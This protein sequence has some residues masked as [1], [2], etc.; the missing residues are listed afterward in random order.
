[1]ENLNDKNNEVPTD[2][3]TA[4]EE[5]TPAVS[6]ES[7]CTSADPQPAP[8][9]E[10]TIE[11][12]SE[13]VN[14][15]SCCEP[16]VRNDDDGE[17]EKKGR[18]VLIFAIIMSVC[19]AVTLMALISSFLFGGYHWMDPTDP[20]TTDVPSDSNTPDEGQESSKPSQPSEPKPGEGETPDPDEIPD[21]GGSS[22]PTPKPDVDV[23]Y[24]NGELKLGD[25]SGKELTRQEIS[26]LGNP[27]VVAITVTKTAGTGIG[28]GVIMTEDG[29]IATN[30]HVVEDAK[31]ITVQTYDGK[32]FNAVTVGSSVLDDLAVIKIDA[33]DL[34]FATFGDSSS[35]Q[36]GD[37][38]TVI[39]HPAGLKFGWT[40]TYGYV[41]AINRDVEIHNYDGTLLHKMTL[42]QIDADVNKG[43]SGGPMFNDRGEVIGIINMRLTGSYEGMGFAIPSKVAV[44]LLES[45]MK[46]GTTDGVEPESSSERPHIGITGISLEK[47]HYYWVG[48]TFVYKL[49][50]A[51]AATIEGSFKAEATGV[52][53]TSVSTASDAYGKLI[54][55]DIITA[56]NGEVMSTMDEMRE[57]LYGLRIGDTVTIT[58]VRDGEEQTLSVLLTPPTK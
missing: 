1:M 58:Y 3:R 30:A 43:N 21:E 42:L 36:V 38:T 29:Y 32:T 37:S 7:D 49:S 5:A 31:T 8:D 44:P 48:D 25:G 50:E 56:I 51:Q 9:E 33:D 20:D 22:E 4:R 19:F 53:V 57:Y 28:S 14:Q 10:G 11:A 15:G 46:T 24:G 27:V 26:A 12:E 47:D 17:E 2:D 34:P 35:V 41:S 55:S 40:S 54:E 23:P 45:L 16:P 13:I 6:L 39:G 18:G 52:F